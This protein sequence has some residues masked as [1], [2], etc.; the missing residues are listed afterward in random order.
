MAGGVADIVE[1]VVLAAGAHAFLHRGGADIGPLLRPGEDVLE[2]HHAGIGEEQGGVVARHQRR[3]R[4]HGVAAVAR[5]N[6]GIRRGRRTGFS[7]GEFVTARGQTLSSPQPHAG[8]PDR[9]RA[10]KNEGAPRCGS[11]PSPRSRFPHAQQRNRT[12]WSDLQSTLRRPPFRRRPAPGS[13][14]SGRHWRGS[15]L[16]SC[17]RCRCLAARKVL[18]ASRPWPMRLPS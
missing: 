4:H 14:R 12:L 16:R 10:G 6:P 18:A 13:G 8:P 1:V 2:L 17:R 3:G 11:A 5:R 15:P 7:W 9:G